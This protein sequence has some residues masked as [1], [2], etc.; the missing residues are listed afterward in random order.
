[1]TAAKVRRPAHWST[2]PSPRFGVE[3]VET[4]VEASLVEPIGPRVLDCNVE[5]RDPR[6]S[7]THTAKS[8]YTRRTMGLPSN[9]AARIAFGNADRTARATAARRP[10]DAG[11]AHPIGARGPVHRPLVHLPAAHSVGDPVSVES[12]RYPW[13]KLDA[14]R[15]AGKA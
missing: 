12:V 13:R 1:M 8:L 2:G 10:A 6:L 14:P 9:A 7:Q 11:P 3:S 4:V 5:E 15:V